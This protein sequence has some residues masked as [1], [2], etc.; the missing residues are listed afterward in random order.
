MD[1]TRKLESW[2]APEI[3]RAIGCPERTAYSWKKG[4]RL[5]PEWAQRLVLERLDQ[6]HANNSKAARERGRSP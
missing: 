6:E 5:P 4:E 3:M 1:F 2:T